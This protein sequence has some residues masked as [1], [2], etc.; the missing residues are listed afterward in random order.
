MDS[1][2]KDIQHMVGLTKEKDALHEKICTNI[3]NQIIN[4]L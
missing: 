3:T 4:L 2:E 1:I